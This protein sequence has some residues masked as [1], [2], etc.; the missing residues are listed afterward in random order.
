MLSF[1]SS[2]ITINL[3]VEQII[4]QLCENVYSVKPTKYH[5]HNSKEIIND[6]IVMLLKIKVETTTIYYHLCAV[7]LIK[8]FPPKYLKSNELLVYLLMEGNQNDSFIEFMHL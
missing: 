7:T 4:V 8:I 1:S 2:G 3:K 5:T 6:K